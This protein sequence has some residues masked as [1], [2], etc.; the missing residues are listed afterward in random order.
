MMSARRRYESIGDMRQRLHVD[1]GD[2]P[3]T[4]RQL[5][6]VA[7]LYPLPGESD[8]SYARPSLSSPI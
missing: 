3:Q 8:M 5:C 7:S 2:L 4:R 6:T 1:L